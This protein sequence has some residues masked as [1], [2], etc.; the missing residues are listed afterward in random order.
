MQDEPAVRVLDGIE[1]GTLTLRISISSPDLRRPVTYRNV[2]AAAGD[3]TTLAS[4]QVPRLLAILMQNGVRPVRV[5]ALGVEQSL[6]PR[7]RAARIVG[8]RVTPRR[9]RPG[10]RATLRLVLQPWQAA[11]R[12][13]R[14]PIR[15]P[16]GVG[17]GLAALRVVPNTTD[18]FDPLPADLTQELGAEAGP[19][20]RRAAVAAAERG[21]ARA[22]GTR[23]ERILGGLRRA[24][25]D[26]N[27]AVRL[28]APGEDAEEDDAG[29]QLAVPFVIYGG[30]ATARIVVPRRGAR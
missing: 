25:D 13:V 23:L 27:D 2:Y 18:G 10:A 9:V 3:V 21:A 15:I 8:A 16:S 7:V 14:V 19:A 26:R 28:L 5:S 12:V 6:Q 29:R 4:G 11:T 22:T 24:T 17:P 30:R 1:G 20:V